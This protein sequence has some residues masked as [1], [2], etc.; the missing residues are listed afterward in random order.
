MK[1]KKNINDGQLCVKYDGSSQLGIGID[2]GMWIK[3]RNYTIA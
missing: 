1:S 2:G 3:A